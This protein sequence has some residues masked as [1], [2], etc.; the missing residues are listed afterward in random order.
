MDKQSFV[1]CADILN[2]GCD[3]L[4]AETLRSSDK[5]TKIAIGSF[6]PSS[7]KKMR[8][9]VDE[10]RHGTIALRGNFHYYLRV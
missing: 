10:I 9:I 3:N 2:Y 5:Q 4:L 7:S 1:Q 6:W 8:P